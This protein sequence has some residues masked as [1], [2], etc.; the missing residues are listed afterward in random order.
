MCVWG[1]GQHP[2]A[3]GYP[4]G[5]RARMHDGTRDQMI[6]KDPAPMPP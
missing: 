5:G 6:S 1:A 3:K 2:V 4:H